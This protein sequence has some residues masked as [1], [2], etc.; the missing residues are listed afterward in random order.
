MRVAGIIVALVASC[1]EAQPVDYCNVPPYSSLP[2]CVRGL[3]STPIALASQCTSNFPLTTAA[4]PI[5]YTR[6]GTAYCPKSDGTF[7]QVA[8]NVPRIGRY[9]ILK[10]PGRSQLLTSV[11]DWS[12]AAWTKTS[13]TCALTATGADGA[14]S[15]ASTCTASGANGTAIQSYSSTSATRAGSFSVRRRTGTGTISVTIDN[16]TTWC[17]VTTALYIAMN[18]GCQWLRLQTYGDDPRD[19]AQVCTYGCGALTATATNYG[20][21]VRVSTAGDAVDVDFAQLEAGFWQTTPISG[22]SRSTETITMA[23]ARW[24]GTSGFY[25]AVLM[26]TWTQTAGDGDIRSIVDSTPSSGVRLYTQNANTTGFIRDATTGANDLFASGTYTGGYFLDWPPAPF[27]QRRPRLWRMS[28]SAGA[29]SLEL[30]GRVMDTGTSANPPT[31]HGT[32]HIGELYDGSLEAQG[33][34]S[35]FRVGTLLADSHVKVATI[36]DSI[37]DG[38]NVVRVGEAIQRELGWSRYVVNPLAASGTKISTVP[39][40]N[41]CT[42]R[43]ALASDANVIVYNCGINDILGGATG[44]ATWTAAQTL[45]NT[46]RG[47]GKKVVVASIGPC[48]GYATCNN[49]HND[50][51]N[52]SLQSWC[53]SEGPIN[54]AYVDANALFKDP[55][56]SSILSAACDVN[57]FGAVGDHLHPSDACSLQYAAALAGAVR[58]L[59]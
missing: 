19:T 46:M 31:T 3:D 27:P 51:Y 42:E 57:Y 49:T 17:D 21:G 8:A 32:A 36:G 9:G 12:Q 53:T 47:A 11:R 5:T 18:N 37:L 23:T 13:M 20:V 4:G 35:R 45:L 15:S 54:C 40:D 24:P 34:F 43:Y 44:A 25:E 10:E 30:Q 55:N 1:A 16:G 52:A 29:D 56:N 33:F 41:D 7:V 6:S 48:G 38:A 22:A 58:A 39:A 28:W 2:E 59:Q 26:P 14:A 50:T